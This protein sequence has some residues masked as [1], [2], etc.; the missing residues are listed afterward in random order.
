MKVQWQVSGYFCSTAGNIAEDLVLQYL[1]QHGHDATDASRQMGWL[2]PSP[3]GIAM[4]Q[5]GGL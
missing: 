4:C 5:Q 3:D 1:E 2:P